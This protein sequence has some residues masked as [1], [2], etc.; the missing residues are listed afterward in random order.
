MA[1]GVKK[2]NSDKI[3]MTEEERKACIY[4]C[5]RCK[6]KEHLSCNFRLCVP[7]YNWFSK[8]WNKFLK[9]FK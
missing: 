6:N 3:E 2:K 7:F 9:T 5:D 1:L 8:E 4:P